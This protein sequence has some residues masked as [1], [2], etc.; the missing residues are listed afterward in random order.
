MASPDSAAT[1]TT[2]YFTFGFDHVHRIDGRT[3][4]AD[5]IVCIT[6][7]DPRAVMLEMFGRE[8]CGEYDAVPAFA[9][10]RGLRVVDIIDIA[11][12]CIVTCGGSEV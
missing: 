8:W 10:R 5:T 3:Y 7:D 2:S 1:L 6:A 9:R 4:D 12:R 11:G